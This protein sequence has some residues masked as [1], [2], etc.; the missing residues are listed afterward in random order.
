MHL[1]GSASDAQDAVQE[2]FASLVESWETIELRGSLKGFPAVCVANKAR[3]MLRRRGLAPA[4]R[5]DT[6]QPD[7]SEPLELV[8]QSEQVRRLRE[9]CPSPRCYNHRRTVVL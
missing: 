6:P 9:R 8:I 5:H 2:V 4:G 7:G 3:D 1:L